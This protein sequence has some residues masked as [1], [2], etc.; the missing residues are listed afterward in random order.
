MGKGEFYEDINQSMDMTTHTY[1]VCP[2]YAGALS[3]PFGTYGYNSASHEIHILDI[4]ALHSYDPQRDGREF[5]ILWKKEM[6]EQERTIDSVNAFFAR[7]VKVIPLLNADILPYPDPTKY[8][9]GVFLRRANRITP[10]DA[11][12]LTPIQYKDRKNLGT[13][14]SS[15]EKL[16]E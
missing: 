11:G 8:D 13:V 16:L 4:T 14:R 10:Y 15:W 7:Y 9:V 2:I 12:V 6:R 3:D 5:S 1:Y